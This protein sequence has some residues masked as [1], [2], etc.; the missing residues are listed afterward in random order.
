MWRV[1]FADVFLANDCHVLPTTSTTPMAV[2]MRA[3]TAAFPCPHQ[4]RGASQSDAANHVQ[5]ALHAP[6]H[7]RLC[8]LLLQPA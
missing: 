5:I 1:L 4:Q 3:C 8:L 6:V 2:R 7:A